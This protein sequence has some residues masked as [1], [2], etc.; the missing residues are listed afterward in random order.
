MKNYYF[1]STTIINN[2]YINKTTSKITTK[3]LINT[4]TP[5]KYNINLTINNKI[6]I[7]FNKPYLINTYNQYYYITNFFPILYFY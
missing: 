6:F 1:L 7:Y 3:K 2:T 5:I 4:I